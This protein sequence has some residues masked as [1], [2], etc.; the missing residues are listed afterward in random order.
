MV[1][2]LIL[3]GYLQIT[4]GDYPLLQTTEKAYQLFDEDCQLTMKLPKEAEIK[5]VRR[6]PVNSKLYDQLKA[7]RIKFAKKNHIPP[8]LVFSD[9]SLQEMCQRLPSTKEELLDISGVGMVKYNQYGESFIK[10]IASFKSH[11]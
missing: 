3:Q 1:Q 11:E 8:Y 2:E 7:L 9:K 4:S 10:V 6:E 5:T